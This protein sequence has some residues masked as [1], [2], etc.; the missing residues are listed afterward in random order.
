[1]T[2][3]NEFALFTAHTVRVEPC[4]KPYRAAD[5][6]G[7]VINREMFDLS[8]AQRAALVENGFVVVPRFHKQLFSAYVENKDGGYPSFVTA[9]LLLHTFHVMYNDTL[10]RLE[11]KVFL[12]N[13]KTLTWAMLQASLEQHRAAA[14]SEVKSAAER[15]IC[16]FA[17]AQGILLS[18]NVT[19]LLSEP[20]AQK[21]RAELKLI[22][23]HNAAMPSPIFGYAEDYTHYIPKGH[24]DESTELRRYFQCMMWYSRMVFRVA[25]R[26]ST[27]ESKQGEQETLSTLLI[28]LALKN[29]KIGGSDALTLWDEIY[30]PI[31]FFVGIS[32]DPNVYDYLRIA[33]E[34]FGELPSIEELGDAAKIEQFL[35]LAQKLPGPSISSAALPASQMPRWATTTKGF[36]FMGSRFI[37]DSY[38]LMELVLPKVVERSFPMGLDV[39]AVLG[40]KRAE[41]ILDQVYQE[42]RYEGYAAQRERLIK[43]F[44]AYPVT[45]WTQ[46][47][48]WSWLYCLKALLGK[49]RE[50]Y[51]PFMQSKAW[52][53]KELNT[54][55]GSWAE[56]R[57]DVLLYAKQP[58]VSAEMMEEPRVD[59]GYVDPVPEFYA[60][61]AALVHMTW[62][63]LVKRELLQKLEPGPE[64]EFQGETDEGFDAYIDELKK[65]EEEMR[66]ASEEDYKEL[67][68]MLLKLKEISEKEMEN[69]PLSE[70]EYDL[71]RDIGYSVAQ[72]NFYPHDPLFHT[73]DM[74]LV[75]DVHT[76][77]FAHG[78]CLEEAVGRAMELYAVVNIEDRLRIAR[79]SVFSYYEFQRPVA[80]RETDAQWRELQEK[81]PLP[82]LPV[83]TRSFIRGGTNVD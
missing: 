45:T 72:L 28:T 8:A 37:P 12:A 34:V 83:W 76:E 67:E 17:T 50:G 54:A 40:S 41:E 62:D 9:D 64:P 71:V 5:D 22:K 47:L 51:P 33:R 49:S 46:N 48:Y 10:E 29:T 80:E 74:S 21:V 1:M 57:H 11:K 77:S 30:S 52:Q 13:L 61:L 25:P 15:N 16:F 79:G 6:L 31:S 70:Q 68:S 73:E 26:E 63:G 65:W 82:P 55:L 75:A 24:Y 2:F 60:R 43:E 32:D 81:G 38:I 69:R 23:D 14:S 53:N 42:F 7:N 59:L 27:E 58:E 35:S 36:R 20:L 78:E 44:S 56:L 39:M 66:Y 4:V 19:S 18:D 3:S